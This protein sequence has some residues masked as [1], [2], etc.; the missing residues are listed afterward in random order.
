MSSNEVAVSIRGV[1]KQYTIRHDYTAPTTLAEAIVRRVRH[2]FVRPSREDF[3]ALRD[4]SFDIQ[5]G[6]VLGLIGG[7][8]AGKSTL[9]KILSRITEMTNGEVNLFGRVGSLLEVGTGFNQELTG[10]ENIF[11]N[12]AILGMRRAEIREQFDAIVAFAGVDRF[13][14]TPVKHYSSGMYVRLAFAV[15]A[16]L[17]SEILIVDEV[18]AVGDLDFQR[19]CLG[20]M[21]DVADGGRTVVL[22]SHNMAAISNLCSRAVVLRG[23]RLA[24]LG[25]VAGAVTQY[26]SREAS[27]MVGDL[28]PR[29][30]RTGNGEVR[31]ISLALRTAS[32]EL[33]RAV[34][35]SEPFEIVV[36]Y[37]ARTA[38]KDVAINIDV[39]LADGT[40]L[41]TL[42][43]DFHG[44]RFSISAGPGTFSC[45]VAGLPL[46]PD[47]YVLNIAIGA[48]Q[49]L[50]DFVERAMSFEVA[51]VDV[52]G[53]GRLPQH[54]Q[55][56]LIANYRW[57][58]AEP[59]T[60]SN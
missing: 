36:E 58:V 32:G 23:G 31:A 12:G 42:H 27:E 60:I 54:N 30:D 25:P 49:V 11:L 9:L 53:T 57:R 29:R 56:P 8:G 43:S 46:R 5:R 16:H 13:L 50:Y 2:P 3:W 45:A 4:V 40:R 41:A 15:A 44:E 14:D 33:T 19:K 20:K 24:Y 38:L 48:Q 7:N 55:G 47:T 28:R 17:R 26:L 51:P 37:E 10:R 34:A 52:Y 39:D 59:A 18:L 1:G 6:E 22:V 21:R 35:P